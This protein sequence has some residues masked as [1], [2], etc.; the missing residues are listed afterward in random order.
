VSCTQE[1]FNVALVITSEGTQA[2]LGFL[3][4][5]IQLSPFVGLFVNDVVPASGF[6]LASLVEAS[7]VGYSRQPMGPATGLVSLPGGAARL[8]WPVALW[9]ASGDPPTQTAYG[10]FVVQLDWTAT[11][12]LLW[13]ER[14]APKVSLPVPTDILQLSPLFD[15]SSLF[16]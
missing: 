7:F 13:I 12:R 9:F 16:V 8:T 6:T 2:L 15:F 5:G 11:P 1:G 3:Q 14:M 10:Y 4:R